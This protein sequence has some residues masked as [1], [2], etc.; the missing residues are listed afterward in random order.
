MCG[1]SKILGYGQQLSLS[2]NLA[3]LKSVFPFAEF[4][5]RPLNA[6]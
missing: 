1:G 2:L 4:D 3:A 5:G 6:W